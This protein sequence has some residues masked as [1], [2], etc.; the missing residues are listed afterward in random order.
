MTPEI[1]T[2]TRKSGLF[3]HVVAPSQQESTYIRVASVG[4]MRRW[5]AGPN[6]Q[7]EVGGAGGLGGLG[8]QNRHAEGRE[9]LGEEGRVAS[10]GMTV[11]ERAGGLC[12]V[13]VGPRVL[14]L[15]PAQP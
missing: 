5:V 14:E 12:S 10:E 9:K 4:G 3:K 1:E 15:W 2:G 13:L 6:W 7:P 11:G 8:R